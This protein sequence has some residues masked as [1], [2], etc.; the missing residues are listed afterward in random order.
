MRLDVEQENAAVA[1]ALS[2]PSAYVLAYAD[3]PGFTD[4]EA[5]IAVAR[6]AR[7]EVEAHEIDKT[8]IVKTED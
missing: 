2:D 8:M 4:R 7:D 1:L 3:L 5:R 6:M